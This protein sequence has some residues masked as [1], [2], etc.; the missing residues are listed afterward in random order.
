[1]EALACSC[2]TYYPPKVGTPRREFLLIIFFQL[3]ALD[4]HLVADVMFHLHQL[5]VSSPICQEH[6]LEM[7][8]LTQKVCF[9]LCNRV[10]MPI[11]HLGIL[12]WIIG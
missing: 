2:Y 12:T 5:Y 1:M 9:S 10:L 8:N 11:F 4:S 7:G 3:A 6:M